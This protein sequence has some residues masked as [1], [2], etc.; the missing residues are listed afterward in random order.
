MAGI[1]RPP[2]CSSRSPITPSGF[3][4]TCPQVAKGHLS[5]CEGKT[6]T[7]WTP[8]STGDPCAPSSLWGKA[9]AAPSPLPA[10]V[11]V[12]NQSSSFSKQVS[13]ATGCLGSARAAQRAGR[14]WAHS[15]SMA[16]P[17]VPAKKMSGSDPIGP[18]HK[19]PPARSGPRTAV[20]TA[21]QPD[22]R[23]PPGAMRG[24]AQSRSLGGA[25]TEAS[26]APRP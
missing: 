5:G 13:S 9:R 7:R 2:S 20:R 24:W 21:G 17:G 22:D 3:G 8:L 16:R 18:S 23:S 12:L 10:S 14:S 4:L 1:G 6:L 19:Q 25:W 15:E 11:T 26:G